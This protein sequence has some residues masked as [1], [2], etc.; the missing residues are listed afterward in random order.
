M[1]RRVV[2]MMLALAVMMPL[3]AQS[4]LGG[5]I[6]MMSANARNGVIYKT[7]VA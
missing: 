4:W 6:S 2:L 5:D 7:H 1:M 3:A